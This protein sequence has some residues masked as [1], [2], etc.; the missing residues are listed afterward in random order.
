M[1]V[2][3]KWHDNSISKLDTVTPQTWYR[4][5]SIRIHTKQ[6]VALFKTLVSF[7]AVYPGSHITQIFQFQ[8]CYH[9]AKLT[10]IFIAPYWD[11]CKYMELF[12]QYFLVWYIYN[13]YFSQCSKIGKKIPPPTK[14]VADC[15]IAF[16]ANEAAIL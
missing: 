16:S 7:L 10:K 4:R 11:I 1:E 6:S 3:R 9:V 5:L 2:I 15:C 12:E 8:C 13:Q 14:L